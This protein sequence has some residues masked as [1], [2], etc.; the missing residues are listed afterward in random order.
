MTEPHRLPDG[1]LLRFAERVFDPETVERVLRPAFADVHH[2]R[3]SA[4]R[5]WLQQR[6]VVLR[7][8]WG[9]WKALG[10]CAIGD[11]ARNRDGIASVLGVRTFLFM[12]VVLATLMASYASWMIGFAS[13]YGVAS[14]LAAGALLLP[15]NVLVALPVAFFFALAMFRSTGGIPPARLLP[16]AAVGT[17]ACAGIVFVLMMAVAPTTNQAYRT[18]VFAAYQADLRD[19]PWAPLRKGLTEMTLLELNNHIRDA[20]SSRQA[21]LAR[22]HRHERFA[23]VAT[24]G[25]LGLLG[26]ALA[27][28]WRSM[29][30]TFGAALAIVILY[31]VC[32]GFGAGLNTRGYPAAYGTWTANAAFLVI[33]VRL[34]R[35]RSSTTTTVSV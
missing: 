28:R 12:G 29:V 16:S 20:P 15:S 32:F 19:G 25:I 13:K 4:S 27:G 8:Y 7:A 22:A 33:A 18:R 24:V 34:L 30:L 11:V 5:G 31:G 17:L 6:L 1:R 9:L 23:F 14:A 10:L 35:S 26:V 2:E 21:E 3:S